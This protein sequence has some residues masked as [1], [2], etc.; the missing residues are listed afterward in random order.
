MDIIPNR[1]GGMKALITAKHRKLLLY[2][3]SEILFYADVFPAGVERNGQSRNKLATSFL[4]FPFLVGVILMVSV[5]DKSTIHTSYYI[6]NEKK[7]IC[8]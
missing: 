5:I 8:Y 2:L 6:E 7:Y 3:Q 4:V 1:N